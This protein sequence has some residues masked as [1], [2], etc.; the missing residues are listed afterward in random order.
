MM[1]HSPAANIKSHEESNKIGLI[2]DQTGKRLLIRINDYT[3]WL[4]YHIN[5]K[6]ILEYLTLKTSSSSL[7]STLLSATMITQVYHSKNRVEDKYFG[8]VADGHSKRD[9]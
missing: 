8:S 4:H 3:L 2:G 9:S 5:T 7:S 1:S 6:D